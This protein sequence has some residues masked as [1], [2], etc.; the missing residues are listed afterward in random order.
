MRVEVGTSFSPGRICKYG[1]SVFDC[2]GIKI[3][4]L[5][6][7]FVWWSSTYELHWYFCV[8]HIIRCSNHFSSE[9]LH[10]ES[11]RSF[12]DVGFSAFRIEGHA[13][14]EDIN[15]L[16]FV[17]N[18]EVSKNDYW[19]SHAQSISKAACSWLFQL[20]L[21][22]C[23]FALVKFQVITWKDSMRVKGRRPGD[24]MMM[25][26]AGDL[27]W[28][29]LTQDYC[30]CLRGDAQDLSSFNCASD[31]SFDDKTIDQKN[32][33]GYIL[34]LF[35]RA[36]TWSSYP[37]AWKTYHDSRYG[38]QH[39]T[40]Y[41]PL[42][43]SWLNA[44]CSDWNVS[45]QLGEC[46]VLRLDDPKML[47][48]KYSWVNALCSDWKVQGETWIERLILD[49]LP[50][51]LSLATWSRPTLKSLTFEAYAKQSRV[52]EGENKREERSQL[53]E[54]Q[55]KRGRVGK[56]TIQKRNIFKRY[57]AG[58]SRN[59]VEAEALPKNLKGWE[60]RDGSYAQTGI[61]PQLDFSMDLDSF[62]IFTPG[63]ASL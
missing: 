51:F 40:F 62:Y 32:S 23:H 37:V 46:F 18:I 26:G 27:G 4:F 31:V 33:Q 45:T 57:W 55:Y 25:E 8:S 17:C 35:D 15:A 42:E 43:Y 6:S 50:M 30:I 47:E 11:V 29:L 21:L 3:S 24:R 10:P 54:G 14:F 34:K 52:E 12:S 5:T 41:L 58:T 13:F 63:L 49:P 7:L 9:S 60:R 20:L 36:V 19:Y 48:E 1:A 22:A 44:S 16:L 39:L 28:I 38:H 53:E 56:G 2:T 61:R 59:L